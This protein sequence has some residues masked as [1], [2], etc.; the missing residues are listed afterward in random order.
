MLRTY[1]RILGTSLITV[2]MLHGGVLSAA[3]TEETFEGAG[4][5]NHNDLSPA[6]ITVG[7][8]EYEV[9]SG[10][11]LKTVIEPAA[12]YPGFDSARSVTSFIIR[13]TTGAEFNFLGF[14]A[15]NQFEMSE[16]V[17]VSGYRDGNHVAGPVLVDVPWPENFVGF[18]G[19]TGFDN[20][21]EVLIENAD[22]Y[23]FLE[24][25]KRD[26]AVIRHELTVA[27]VGSGTV[28]SSPPGIDCG[29][30]CAASFVEDSNIALTATPDPYWTLGSWTWSGACSTSNDV[31]DVL[32]DANK[33]VQA[34]FY[35]DLISIDPPMP[36]IDSPE[37]AWQCF[38]LEAVL[39]FQIFD[40][41]EVTFI[42][43]NSIE[44]GVGFQV[45]LG[46]IFRAV[47]AP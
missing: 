2:L 38:D 45:G 17:S 27:V 15:S 16:Q 35:C 36:P 41:G 21:D 26:L 23:F 13:H 6:T 31:C 18:P 1:R 14:N 11:S 7:D 39:G 20:V 5:T 4:F 32:L 43:E 30:T 47:I 9:Q 42:A 40:G 28:E 8:F 34:N 22:L 3:V 10:G 12:F 24:A 25:R 19:E 44:L 37:P 33:T 29:I 46:G